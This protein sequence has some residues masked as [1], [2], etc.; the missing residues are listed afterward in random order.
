MVEKVLEKKY[1]KNKVDGNNAEN[2]EDED[3]LDQISSMRD[4][5]FEQDKQ[6]LKDSTENKLLQ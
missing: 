4:A 2:Q 6:F 1:Q 3:E 5:Q